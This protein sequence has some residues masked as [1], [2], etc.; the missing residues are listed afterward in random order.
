[1][2]EKKIVWDNKATAEEVAKKIAALMKEELVGL[3]GV[4]GN[5]I[6]FTL[7]G[8]QSFRVTVTEK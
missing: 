6:T 7:A 4:E 5:E 3:T 2:E 8:G 1:M